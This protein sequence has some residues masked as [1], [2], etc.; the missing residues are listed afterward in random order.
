MPAVLLL[1]DLLQGEGD[2]AGAIDLLKRIAVVQPNSQILTLLG[3][4][5]T[6]QKDPLQALEYYTKAIK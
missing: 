6:H 3:D 4:I 2:I 5:Y 1:T